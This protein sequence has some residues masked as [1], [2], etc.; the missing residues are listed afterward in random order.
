MGVYETASYTHTT[1]INYIGGDTTK[2]YTIGVGNYRIGTYYNYCAAS[3][4]YYCYESTSGT[5]DSGYDICPSGWKMPSGDQADGSYYDLRQKIS[6]ITTSA[7]SATD[8]LGLVAMLSTP[9]SGRY[10]NAAALQQGSHGRFWSSTYYNASSMCYLDV[11]GASLNPQSQHSR[12]NGFSVRCIA[13][14]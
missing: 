10:N 7:S 2:P 12:A 14:N 5:G 11:M 8:P 13:Q 9:I 6:N 1:A 3:A 4:G